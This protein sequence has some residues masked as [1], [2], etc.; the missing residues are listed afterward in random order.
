[1]TR[2]LLP[3]TIALLLLS[4]LLTIAARL[5]IDTAPAQPVALVQP[6]DIKA[7]AA[8]VDRLVHRLTEDRDALRQRLGPLRLT[9]LDAAQRHGVDPALV[10]AVITV[11]SGWRPGLV[12]YN[13]NGTYDSG[14][15]QINSGTWPWLARQAGVAGTDPLD[16][17]A[18]IEAGT[19][20]LA[21]LGRR[22]GPDL[23][24]VLTAYN[25]GE[26]GLA[27]WVVSRGTARSSYSEAVL[28][29][30]R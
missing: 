20:Y 7:V 10:A 5:T 24:R 8:Q 21:Y 14:I 28:D 15:F 27:A 17:E 12:S 29:R 1:M 25:R 23:D 6:A 3:L 30:A 9:A 2:H 13:S 4:I 22:Y 16:P 19:W 18:N 26:G 11:E